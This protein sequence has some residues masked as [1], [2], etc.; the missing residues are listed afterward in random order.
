MVINSINA[1]TS[2]AHT[3]SGSLNILMPGARMLKMVVIKLIEAKSELNPAR[4]S[5][6]RVQSIPIPGW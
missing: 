1:V 2:R 4:C 3:N 6:K 5:P